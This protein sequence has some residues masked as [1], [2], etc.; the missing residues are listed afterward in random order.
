[1]RSRINAFSSLVKGRPYRFVATTRS[2]FSRVREEPAC[3]PE[4]STAG[5]ATAFMSHIPINTHFT[6]NQQG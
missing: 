5:V 4:K 6:S 2:T 1:M 3:R